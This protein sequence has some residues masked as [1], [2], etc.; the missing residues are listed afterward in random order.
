MDR[1]HLLAA[2]A[3]GGLAAP[4]AA[5]DTQAPAAAPVDLT[6]I[7]LPVIS[8]G[9]VRN[10]VFAEVRLHLTPGTDVEAVR[11]K[12]PFFR[13]ALIRASHLRPFTVAD[14]WNRIDPERLSAAIGHVAPRLVG[15]GTLSRVEVVSQSPRRRVRARAA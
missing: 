4:A 9:R 12:I 6:V 2:A 3:L 8:E 5:A 10:Y 14:D 1:R 15:A 11:R 7:G 13:E